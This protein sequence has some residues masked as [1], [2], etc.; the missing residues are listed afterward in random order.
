MVVFHDNRL[1]SPI[2]SR[3]EPYGRGGYHII[4]YFLMKGDEFNKE[5]GVLLYKLGHSDNE[6]HR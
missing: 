1:T 4:L 5:K 6:L 3:A 2:G